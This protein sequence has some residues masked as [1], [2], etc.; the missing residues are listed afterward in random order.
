MTDTVALHM[1]ARSKQRRS[2]A[3]PAV[4]VDR[5]FPYRSR[6]DRAIG[7]ERQGS[8]RQAAPCG[9]DPDL[10]RSLK[11]RE[12]NS[13]C[14]QQQVTPPAPPSPRVTRGE[15]ARPPHPLLPA[16]SKAAAP[17]AGARM[18]VGSLGFPEEARRG[19][20]GAVMA[21]RRA[22]RRPGRRS[23]DDSWP[24]GRPLRPEGALPGPFRRPFRRRCRPRARATAEGPR[25]PPGERPLGVAMFG[26]VD[27]ARQDII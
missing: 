19:A 24:R 5:A 18:V 15:D 12:C 1:R 23:T 14:K 6:R 9:A 7:R 16:A 22:P 4:G 27:T 26:E 10:P 25:D 3:D 2:T 8:A 20:D 17:A 11:E 21:F 13:G